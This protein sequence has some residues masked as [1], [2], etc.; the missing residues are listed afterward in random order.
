MRRLLILVLSC[1]FIWLIGAPAAFA[2]K[3]YDL[4]L[5][6]GLKNIHK[7]SDDFLKACLNQWGSGNVY[8][9]YLNSSNDVTTR[10][11]DGKTIICIG[12]DDSTAGTEYISEQAEYLAEKVAIL[13]KNYGLSPQFDIVAHSMGGLVSRYYIYKNPY[14]VAGLVTLGTPHHGSPLANDDEWLGFLLGAEHAMENL[15]PEWVENFN[16]EYP[17]TGSPLYK[18]GKIFTIRGDADGYIWEWGVAGEIF[19]GWHHLN[20][21]YKT[22]SDGLVPADS[23]LITGATHIADFWDYDHLELVQKSDVA[24]KAAAYLP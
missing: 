20:L 1:C 9:V 8:V 15:K 16:K 23:A 19:L 21:I 7:W 12:K 10:T 2:A 11:I 22:D 13:Q 17:V 18:K 3:K 6:H 4:V 14:T 24:T 5:V